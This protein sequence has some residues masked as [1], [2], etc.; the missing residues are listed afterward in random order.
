M[1]SHLFV[2]VD[3]FADWTLHTHDG[4]FYT[5]IDLQLSVDGDGKNDINGNSVQ[6]RFIFLPYIVLPVSFFFFHYL[7]HISSPCRVHSVI[8]V[9]FIFSF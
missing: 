7:L 2:S 9:S 3:L 5:W 4:S 6:Q 8:L 1:R